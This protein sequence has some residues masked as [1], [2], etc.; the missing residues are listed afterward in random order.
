MGVDSQNKNLKCTAPFKF[1]FTNFNS[2]VIIRFQNLN[3]LKSYQNNEG[4][5]IK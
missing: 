3:V 2:F 1:C 4:A 5:S